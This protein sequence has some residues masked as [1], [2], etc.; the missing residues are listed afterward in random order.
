LAHAVLTA[1]DFVRGEPFFMYLG[2]NVLLE[3]SRGSFVRSRTPG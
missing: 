1:A 2:D 3:G